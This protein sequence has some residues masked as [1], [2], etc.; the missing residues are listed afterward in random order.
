MVNPCMPFELNVKNMRS[1]QEAIAEEKHLENKFVFMSRA[2]KRNL[3]RR[4]KTHFWAPELQ[5][6]FE[7]NKN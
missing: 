6:Y 5:N 1:W 7:I 4:N 3:F 2:S